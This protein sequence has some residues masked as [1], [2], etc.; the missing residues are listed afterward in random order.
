RVS[1]Y[2]SCF[3]FS[4]RRRHTRFS[5]DWSSDVCSSDLIRS[6]QFYGFVD[7]GTVGN[8]KGGYGGG[9]LA[10]AGGGLRMDLGAKLWADLGAA[11]PLSGPAYDRSDASPRLHVLVS[12]AF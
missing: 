1:R 6:I 12:K 5:R 4:S 3:F 7:G 9:S 10:S 8:R 2:L 11:V